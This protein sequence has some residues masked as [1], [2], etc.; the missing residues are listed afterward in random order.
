MTK[1]LRVARAV[2]LGV[3]LAAPW[4]AAD[5]LTDMISPVSAPTTN[6]DPRI[7]TELRPMYVYHQISNGFVTGGGRIQAAAV[8]A[9]VALTDRI[10]F[11][12]TKDGYAW[13]DTDDVLPDQDG[14]MNLAFG[15][16]GSVWQDEESASIVSLGLRYEAPS[17]NTDV[18]QGEGDGVL[19]PFLS[20]AKGIDAGFSDVHLQL[21]SG[22][23]LPI[24]GDDSTFWDT[25][26]HADYQ[27]GA[28]YPLA[29]LNWVHVLDSGRRIPIDQEGF[30]ILNLGSTDVDGD[31]VLTAAFGARYR[32]ADWLDLGATGEFPI[33]NREDIFGWRVTA[34]VII[35]PFGWKL[36]WRRS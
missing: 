3:V 31:D 25:S 36:P 17:G 2:A 19:N 35:R 21:Y 4:A 23:R 6:E 14:W 11:I 7:T 15:F 34:D 20:A 29:E 5:Q 8:Q 13:L 16:K 10:G 26:L 18:F 24:S 28:F 22:P 32:V 9:R 12:A 30:D 1:T 27:V 33:T